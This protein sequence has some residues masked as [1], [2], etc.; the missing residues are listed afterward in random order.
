[1]GFLRFCDSECLG[2]DFSSMYA[3]ESARNAQRF[4]D[5]AISTQFAPLIDTI[6]SCAGE[7]PGRRLL[8]VGC[9]DGGVAGYLSR[10]YGYRV[11]G[12]DKEPISLAVAQE[13]NGV[14]V[15]HAP[16]GDIN[17]SDVADKGP[18][19]LV[20]MHRVAEM[21]VMPE[22]EAKKLVRS[23]MRWLTPQGSVIISTKDGVVPTKALERLGNLEDI[24]VSLTSYVGQVFRLSRN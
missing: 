16:N 13:L 15:C 8:D 18:Y 14:E 20:Y 6:R 17:A 1:M 2:E 22:Y 4:S 3:L 12:V 11:L 23:L 19:D 10:R 24:P 7:V 5:D 21:P 9:A